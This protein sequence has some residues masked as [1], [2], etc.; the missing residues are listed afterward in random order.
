MTPLLRLQRLAGRLAASGAALVVLLWLLGVAGHPVPRALSRTAVGL[1]L[2]LAAVALGRLAAGLWRGERL[3]RPAGRILL[4]A[5]AAAFLVA[6]AGL[7]HEIGE[8]YFADE[9]TFLAE[10][11]RINAGR[12]LRPWFVYPHFLF[13]WDA[14]AL[15]LADLGGPLVPATARLVWGVEG[16]LEVAALVTRCASSALA[17]LAVVAVFLAARRLAGL[18]AAAAAA[19][20]LVLSPTW[21]EIGHTNLADVPAAAFAAAALWAVAELLARESAR[22]YL[23]A[24]CAAGLAAGS[25][26]PAGLVALAI[27]APWLRGLRSRR[28]GVSLGWIAGTALAA[29]GAFLLTTPS[30]LRYTGAALGGEGADVLFGAR[31]YSKAGWQGIVRESNLLYYL[32]ELRRAF[33]LPALALGAAGWALLAGETRR[34][35]AWLLPFPVLFMALLLALEVA[36]RRN[37]MPVLPFFA[38]LLGIGLGGVR[39]RL[40]RLS[41]AGLRRPAAAALALAVLAAPAAAT[42]AMLV[43]HSRP[44]TR[45]DAAAWIRDHLPPGSFLVQEQYTPLLTPEQLFPARKPR[46]VGRLASDALRDAAHDFVLLSSGAYDRFLRPHNLADLANEDVARRYREI[47]A[48][49]PLVREWAPGRLQDGPVLRLYRVDPQPLAYAA[50]RDL[51]AAS[52]WVSDPAMKPEGATE[53]V[54]AA[55]DGWALFK[56]HLQAGRYV[57]RVDAAR[58]DSS[59]ADSGRLRVRDRDNLEHARVPV[60]AAGAR[61]ELPRPDK[62]FLYLE[63]PPGT[64]LR[65]LG[66]SR[67]TPAP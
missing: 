14:L 23:A 56:A 7:G 63:L 39:Q 43:R 61:F 55:E 48:S 21:V 22:G 32:G 5:V 20:L 57:A 30:F 25:K 28:P 35:A 46:F 15:W 34:R 49:L 4:L 18:G 66:V 33:G 59:G 64:R 60:D 11:R 24:G 38:V 41:I 53:V 65:S 47:F 58:S 40:A 50:A 17:A 1:T 62:Y 29:L 12:A 45:E 52:A 16:E 31:L 36:L 2:A 67:D 44:T 6:L 26:Y 3:E 54:F 8:L 51:P 42:V 10:A 9:G 37:L 19:A 13:Y 27:A